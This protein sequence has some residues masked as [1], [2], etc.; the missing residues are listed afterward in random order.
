MKTSF[1]S[2]NC[3]RGS[4]LIIVLWISFGLVALTLYFGQSMNY[5]LRAADNR[6]AAMEAEQAILGAARYVTNVL[7]RVTEPG[8]IPETTGYRNM[9]AP[10]GESRFWLIGRDDRQNHGVNNAWGL[11]DEGS[12][13]N[14]NVVT[15]EMLSYLPRMTPQ[16]AAAI[17]DWRDSDDEVTENGAE[18]ETYARRNPP[19]RAKNTNYESVAELRLVAGSDLDLMFGEDGNLNGLLDSNENDSETSLPSDN[20]DGRIDPGLMEFFTVYTRIPTVGTNLNSVEDLRALLEAKFGGNRA[21]ELT[22]GTTTYSNILQFYFQSGI[23]RDEMA[24]IEGFLVCTNATNALININTASEYVLA[25]IPG[26]GIELAPQLVAYRQTNPTQLN[27]LAWLGDALGWNWENNRE[28]IMQVGPWICGRAFQFSA[29]IAAVGRHGRGYKRVKYV[30]DVADGFAQTRSRLDLTYLGWGLGR[31]VR[32]S[33]R[34]ASNT[35]R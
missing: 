1:Q 2:R 21:Q 27:T 18:Q 28:Q 29:D 6:V 10:V 12:K 33:L 34:L 13:L 22:R 7:S 11:V 5:E 4:A 26:I 25:C 17:I 15:Y 9:D 3:E 19:Y 23:T 24:Q 16:L 30:F 35:R 14:L 20:R 32:E 31:Q 8:L